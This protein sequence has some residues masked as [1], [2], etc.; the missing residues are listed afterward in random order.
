MRLERDDL[1]IGGCAIGIVAVIW[2][3]LWAIVEDGKAWEELT[4][5]HACER[6]DKRSHGYY[7]NTMVGKTMIMTWVPGQVLYQCDDG[8]GYWRDQ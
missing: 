3:A 5:T 1:V 4:A 6:T 8:N 2:L 7:I